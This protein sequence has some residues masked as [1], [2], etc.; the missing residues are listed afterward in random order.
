MNEGSESGGI[1]PKDE[2]AA[3]A[4]TIVEAANRALKDESG[5][6]LTALKAVIDAGLAEL[7]ADVKKQRTV[8]LSEFAR[9]FQESVGAGERQAISEPIV[10]A[11]EMAALL[12]SATA[13]F[14]CWCHKVSN[15]FGSRDV[16]LADLNEDDASARKV[17]LGRLAVDALEQAFMLENALQLMVAP[18]ASAEDQNA[19]A[20]VER[21][22][23]VVLD[24]IEGKSPAASRHAGAFTPASDDSVSPDPPDTD[25]GET[26][27]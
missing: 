22:A 13:I 23:D 24:H 19:I 26:K 27:D 12:S 15:D 18:E 5:E 6:L 20:E 1:H 9:T 2:G 14:V 16:A 10:G 17:R 3:A 4:E 8:A 25:G 21:E 7:R 11:I